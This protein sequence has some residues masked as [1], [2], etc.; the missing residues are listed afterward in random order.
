MCVAYW[1]P[2]STMT[3]FEATVAPLWPWSQGVVAML[4]RVPTSS[5]NVVLPQ[6]AKACLRSIAPCGS[7]QIRSEDRRVGKGGG[8]TCSYRRTPAHKKKQKHK[9]NNETN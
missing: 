4:T 3:T 6:K 2:P 8:L 1:P 5:T 9:R 7:T